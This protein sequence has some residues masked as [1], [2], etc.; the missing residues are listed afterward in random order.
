MNLEEAKDII[1]LSKEEIASIERYLNYEHMNINILSDFSPETYLSIKA[2]SWSIDEKPEELV[3]NIQDFVNLYS[4][5]YKESRGKNVNQ[6]LVRGTSNKR[7]KDI[8]GV[9]TQFWSTS[10]DEGIAKTFTEYGDGA[11]M[12]IYVGEGV[13]FLD[14][15]PYRSENRLD[16]R[17]II[18]AP[19]CQVS[20]EYTDA[21]AGYTHYKVTMR[22]PILDRKEPEEL[23]ALQEEVISGFSQNIQDIKDLDYLQFRIESMDRAYVQAKGD[24]EEQDYAIEEARKA[25]EEQDR[26]RAKTS[27]FRNKLQALL[28]GLCRQKEIQINQAQELVEEDKAKRKEETERKRKEEIARKETEEKEAVRQK[29][30][31]ELAMKLE[32]NP[33]N[34][35]NLERNILKTYDEF[36]HHEQTARDLAK[37]FK[38]PYNRSIANTSARQLVE[39]IQ[40]NLQEIEAR[41]AEVK[42]DETTALEDAQRVSNEF[43]SRLD[44]VSYGAEIAK[45]FSELVSLDGQQTEKDIKRGIYARVQTALQDARIQRYTEQKASVQEERVGFLGRLM[46]KQQLKQQKL[47]NIDLKMQLAQ[48][49]AEGIPEGKTYS[50]REMLVDMRLCVDKELDG[51]FTPEIQ[52]IYQAI[53]STYKDKDAGEFSEQ[54]IQKLASQRLI[55]QGK[56]GVPALQNAHA[57]RFGKTKAEAKMLEAENQSLKQRMLKMRTYSL[58]TDRIYR[59]QEPDAIA[60]FE[61]RLNGIAVNTQPRDRT[62]TRD[63]EDTLDLWKK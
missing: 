63:K 20:V 22:K 47:E 6:S 25:E 45:N 7:V 39:R 17:E 57:R 38:I 34:I 27:D 4:A 19:F 23:A 56:S 1:Y 37:K 60:L 36:V 12:N 24:K 15:T 48:R 58:K 53:K 13:P 40:M 14:P 49:Q 5:M 28:K 11:L 32:Q 8:Q 50:I 21:Y 52:E 31:S 18:L 46:G 33:T 10:K 42:V 26:L 43:T 62:V 2:T 35:S 55:A 61:Q 54:Y 30:V 44:G 59:E 16:E 29:T 41:V 3:R 51:N 9:I